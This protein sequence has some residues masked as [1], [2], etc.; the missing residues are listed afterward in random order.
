MA[1]APTAPASDPSD[2]WSR[3]EELDKAEPLPPEEDLVLRMEAVSKVSRNTRS[4]R[5]PADMASSSK[6]I[7]SI[8]KKRKPRKKRDGMTL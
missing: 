5:R 6:P 3:F 2:L 4:G 8:E 7:R 1:A